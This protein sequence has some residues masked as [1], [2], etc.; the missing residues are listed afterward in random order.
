MSHNVTRVNSVTPNAQGALVLGMDD[1]ISF[2]PNDNDVLGFDSNGDAASVPTPEG[3]G[4][5]GSSWQAY[6]GWGGGGAIA[7][8]DFLF[9]RYPSNEVELDTTKV[10]VTGGTTWRNAVRLAPGDYLLSMNRPIRANASAADYVDVRLKNITTSTFLGPK[11]RIGAGRSASFSVF[12]VSH[13]AYTDYGWQVIAK[14]G[15]PYF[16]TD[17]QFQSFSFLV[18]ELP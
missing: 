4:A 1:L 16:P 11:F 13:T 15:S 17:V 10:S 6:T 14:N 9:W 12:P 7:V 5:A 18:M 3:F 2:T 8:N